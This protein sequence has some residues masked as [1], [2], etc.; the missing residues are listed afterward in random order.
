MKIC[1]ISN[2]AQ[3]DV[4]V[5]HNNV[6]CYSVSDAM[7]GD[8][9]GYFYLDVF[10]CD[11]KYSHQCMYPLCPSYVKEDEMQVLSA[12]VNLGNLS[13]PREG[14]PSLLL[15]YLF[16][17]FGP[18]MHCVLT[19]SKHSLHSWT[20]LAVPWLGGD[21]R[22]FFEVTTM[23]LENIFWQTEISKQ[24]SNIDDRSCL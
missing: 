8:L 20:W 2:F 5:W 10:S 14:L 4:D 15:F 17:E 18:V 13:P 24:S 16:H 7:I 6:E 22:D 19:N 23:M 9:H 21:E 12:C 1:W 11:G 3:K